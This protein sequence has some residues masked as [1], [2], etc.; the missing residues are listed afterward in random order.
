MTDS[1]TLTVDLAPE[2][3]QRLESV[4]QR[5]HRSESLLAAEA[6]EEFLAVQEWQLA[7]IEEGIA[8]AERGDLIP[9]EDVRAW[10]ES[11][12]SEHE[13]SRPQAK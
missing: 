11:W 10:V 13:L 2:V 6:I 9:H 3:K 5:V 12:G 8:A 1:P 7:A 4:A